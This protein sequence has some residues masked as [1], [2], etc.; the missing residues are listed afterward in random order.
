[1]STIFFGIS[2]RR[3]TYSV[4]KNVGQMLSTK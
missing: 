3:P 2:D 4:Y 1:M